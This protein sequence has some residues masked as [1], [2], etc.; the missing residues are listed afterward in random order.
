MWAL[1]NQHSDNSKPQGDQTTVQTKILESI[2]D[3]WEIIG[4]SAVKKILLEF[5]AYLVLVCET[6]HPNRIRGELTR[7]HALD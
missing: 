3:R 1:L 4:S 2:F 7:S 6:L 5:I